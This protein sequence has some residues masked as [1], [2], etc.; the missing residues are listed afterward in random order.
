MCELKL[1]IG[2][3]LAIYI[4][5]G[6]FGIGFNWLVHRAERRGY[7]EGYTAFFVAFGVIVTVAAISIINQQFALITLG[8]FTASGL[9]MI[10]GSTWR[11]MRAREQA[12][13]SI[14]DQINEQQT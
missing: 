7:L 10:A 5:L 12:Q 6:C 13:R 8:A 11:Y 14:I 3:I 1:D 4:V 2:L 9:P